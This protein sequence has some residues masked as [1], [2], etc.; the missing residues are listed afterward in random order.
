[1]FPGYPRSGHTVVASLLNAHPEI[2]IGHRMRALRYVDEGFD[3]DQIYALA[4]LAD[5]R[6]ARLGRVGSKRYDYSVPG[7][8]Q[9]RFQHLRVLGDGD[10]ATGPLSR[11]PDLFERLRQV[12]GVP[13]KMIHVV[14]NPFDNIATLSMRNRMTLPEAVERYFSAADKASVLRAASP[15]ADWLDLRHE[16][17]LADAAAT[18]S[19]LCAFLGAPAPDDYLQAGAGI[20][21]GKPNQSRGQVSWPEGLVD[22]VTAR[23][24][25]Y[26]FL[27]GYSF[28]EPAP[29]R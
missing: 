20:V 9:G 22:Q 28:A 5:R 4:L 27:R 6:F 25:T 12:T 14:R 1:M 26:E 2:V 18:L 15:D 23:M 10:I 8:W 19:R 29:T 3:R 13:V 17:L 24:A 16:D 11:R 21:Y 7:Q